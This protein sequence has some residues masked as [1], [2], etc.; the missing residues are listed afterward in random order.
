ML[1]RSLRSKRLVSPSPCLSLSA[2]PSHGLPHRVRT[3]PILW[4]PKVPV[5]RVSYP[6]CNVAR[7]YASA[8][9]TQGDTIYALSTAQ[10]R[11]G[12]AVVRISGPSCLDVSPN[13][14]PNDQLSHHPDL[15]RPLSLQA[16]PQTTPRHRPQPPRPLQSNLSPRLPSPPPLLPLPTHRHRRRRSRTAH[17]RRSRYRQ[18]CPV[19]HPTLRSLTYSIRRAG[20]VHETRVLQ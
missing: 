4:R 17:P 14:S 7:S 8:I 20:R 12:I 18:S 13:S 10:G 6:S 15:H 9:P 5:A 19:R 1:Q 3:Y 11:A 16:T 2:A